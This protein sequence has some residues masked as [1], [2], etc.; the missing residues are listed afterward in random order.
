M[1]KVQALSNAVSSSP[2]MND[3]VEEITGSTFIN[4][5]CTRW[6]SVFSAVQRVISIGLDLS[7]IHI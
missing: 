6:S 7:L 2:K 3:I 5:T 4:P 1:G